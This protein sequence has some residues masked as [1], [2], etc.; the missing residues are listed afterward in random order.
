VQS[1]RKKNPEE[2]KRFRF[3]QWLNFSEQD[4]KR[5]TT[6]QQRRHSRNPHGVS[7]SL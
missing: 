6:A 3:L 4:I 1:G 7:S 5:K 2:E